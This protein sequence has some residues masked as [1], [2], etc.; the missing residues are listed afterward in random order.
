MPS[1]NVVEVKKQLCVACGACSKVCPKRAITIWKGCYAMVN[2]ELCVGCGI[3][4]RT[5]P[6]GC[7]IKKERESR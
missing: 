5:C 3:C 1:L 7:I 4:G 2:E 6:V